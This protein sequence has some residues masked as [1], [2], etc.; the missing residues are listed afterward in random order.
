MTVPDLLKSNTE[1]VSV[2]TPT[3][4]PGSKRSA[5]REAVVE[6][7]VKTIINRKNVV[8]EARVISFEV[9][10]LFVVLLLFMMVILVT[11]VIMIVVLIMM[12]FMLFLTVAMRVCVAMSA[13]STCRERK[14]TSVSGSLNH[15]FT[16]LRQEVPFVQHA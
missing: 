2:F 3:V 5:R 13:N 9:M 12:F 6:R 7:K 15:D 8:V 14:Q 1:G 11:V 10:M 4:F 16:T